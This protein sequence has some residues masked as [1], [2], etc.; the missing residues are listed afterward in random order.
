MDP[1][2]NLKRARKSKLSIVN[3]SKGIISKR[4]TNVKRYSKPKDRVKRNEDETSTHPPN[5]EQSS[6]IYRLP[7]ELLADI[8][9]YLQIY[10]LG[11]VCQTSKWFQQVAGYCYTQNYSAFQ[12]LCESKESEEMIFTHHYGERLFAFDKLIQ[13]ISVQGIGRYRRFLEKQLKYQQLKSLDLFGINLTNVGV[14]EQQNPNVSTK[15]EMLR[16]NSCKMGENFIANLPVLFPNLKRLIIEKSDIKSDWINYKYPTLERFQLLSDDIVMVTPFLKLNPNIRKLEINAQ[17]LL[18]NKDSIK[19]EAL[20]VDDLAVW[21]ED[22][23]V[24]GGKFES[25]CLLFNEL[26]ELGVYKRLKLHRYLQ[27]NQDMV[28]KLSSVQGLIKLYSGMIRLNL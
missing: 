11:N 17:L 27:F 15:L 7:I 5:I 14:E 18:N 20:K 24:Y 9:D 22:E 4:R 26:Y 19:T 10:D 12:T 3:K 1:K 16:M 25:L 2:L 13:K 6:D 28:D 21:I 23:I 8:F